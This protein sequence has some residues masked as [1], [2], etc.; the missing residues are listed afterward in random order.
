M[1]H[2]LVL[3]FD[4]FVLAFDVLVGLFHRILVNGNLRFLRFDLL[5]QFLGILRQRLDFLLVGFDGAA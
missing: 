5:F 2:I 1:F 3:A 4:I